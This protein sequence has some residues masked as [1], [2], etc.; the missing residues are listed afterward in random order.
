MAGRKRLLRA[1]HEAGHAVI[2]RKFGLAMTHATAL[3][4]A[5][6]VESESAGWLARN[7]DVPTQVQA[8][9]KDAVVALAGIAAQMQAY[10]ESTVRTADAMFVEEDD[11]DITNVRSAIYKSICL[12]AGKTFPEGDA[13]IELDEV[14]VNEMREQFA[15]LLR[16]ATAMVIQHSAAIKQVAKALERHDRIEQAEVDRLIAVAERPPG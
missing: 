2:T 13:Q 3:S 12:A 14:M 8:Y 16:Q 15:R 6:V 4:M 1:Y 5:A 11:A 9:E 10:P 7:S